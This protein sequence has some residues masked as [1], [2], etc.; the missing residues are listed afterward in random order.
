MDP[1]ILEII[2]YYFNADQ[3]ITI[4]PEGTICLKESNASADIE[5]RRKRKLYQ[6]YKL[7]SDINND[8]YLITK[9]VHTCPKA[10][11]LTRSDILASPVFCGTVKSLSTKMYIIYN[12]SLNMSKGK[13]M[14]QCCHA[15]HM[16]TK[17][18]EKHQPPTY[19]IWDTCQGMRKVC[20]KASQDKMQLLAKLPGSF[21][22]YDAGYT[23]IPAGSLTIVAF[24]PMFALDVPKELK[25][26]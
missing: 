25:E 17:Y 1:N 5:Y 7:Y 3:L 15:Q 16:V 22:V 11:E 2:P 23:E 20:L 4:H 14:A 21:P 8:T 10:T 9:K 13:L 19:K 18:C 24:I 26:L 6:G 12:S